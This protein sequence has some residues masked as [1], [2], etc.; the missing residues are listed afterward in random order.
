GNVYSCGGYNS[1]VHFDS[2]TFK[3]PSNYMDLFIVKYDPNGKVLWAKA[4]GGTG[5]ERARQV[6][7]D[8]LGNV[9][10]TGEF[11]SDSIKIGNTVLHNSFFNNYGCIFLVKYDSAGNLQ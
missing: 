10:V 4:S 9:F 7:T 3:T 8:R 1:E 5:E 11:F 2:F 6:C